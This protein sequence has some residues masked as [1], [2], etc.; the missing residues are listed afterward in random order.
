[1]E[2]AAPHPSRPP[3][4]AD[5]RGGQA[6]RELPGHAWPGLRRR[7]PPGHQRCIRWSGAT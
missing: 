6:A 1:V 4:T 2:N 7:A 3:G 5:L